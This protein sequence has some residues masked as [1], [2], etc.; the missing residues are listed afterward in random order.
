MSGTMWAT[1]WL[2]GAAE[3]APDHSDNDMRKSSTNLRQFLA[4]IGSLLWLA[5][6]G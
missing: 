1:V 5:L 2:A 4:R 6:Q 3:L